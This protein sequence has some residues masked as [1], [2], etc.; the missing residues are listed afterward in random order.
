M[1]SLG[2]KKNFPR[3]RGPL[4]H[5]HMGWWWGIKGGD[6]GLPDLPSPKKISSTE[7][8]NSG[9]LNHQFHLRSFGVKHLTKNTKKS[10]KGVSSYRRTVGANN[11]NLSAEEGTTSCW[12]EV[13]WG[14]TPSSLSLHPSPSPGPTWDPNHSHNPTLRLATASQNP[15]QQQEPWKHPARVSEEALRNQPRQGSSVSP[16]EA[17]GAEGLTQ[18]PGFLTEP[19]GS[20]AVPPSPAVLQG[21][22]QHA[23]P[24]E[25]FEG[26]LSCLVLGC[27]LAGALT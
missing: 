27:F 14:A 19:L 12:R 15:S 18:G 2:E 23:P 3:G 13:C 25:V 6:P 26:H 24:F 16:S 9:K 8:K 21:W 11:A 20:S 17:Y 7:A 5:T 1:K 10:G 4:I 22:L